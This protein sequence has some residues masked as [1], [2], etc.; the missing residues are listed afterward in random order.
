[1]RNEDKKRFMNAWMLAHGSCGSEPEIDEVAFSF[2]LLADYSLNE[3]LTGIKAH[4]LDPETG[5]F[6]VKPADVVR[7]I[8]GSPNERAK[9]AWMKVAQAIEMAGP[10]RRVAFDDPAIHQALAHVGWNSLMNC[11][12]YQD[13]AFRQKEFEQTY[14]ACLNRGGNHPAYL[15]AVPQENKL[16]PILIGDQ[17][18]AIKVALC[19]RDASRMINGPVH[20]SG[21]LGHDS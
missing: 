4:A 16:D 6:P 18:K 3:V 10:Y 5:Q 20:I 13:L 7:H 12:T 21:I 14:K 9:L 2:N 11:Q 15:C 8:E 17:D 19:G 1:M